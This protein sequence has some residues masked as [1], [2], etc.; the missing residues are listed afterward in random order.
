[1][2]RLEHEA[3]S[4]RVVYFYKNEENLGEKL[5][6]K[7]TTKHFVEEGKDKSVIFNVIKRF[8]TRGTIDYKKITGRPAFRDIICVEKILKKDSEISIRNGAQKVQIYLNECLIK[9]LL[10]FILKN[11]TKLKIFCCGLICRLL[12]IKKMC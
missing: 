2:T 10:P 5:A 6:L 1:M 7:L 12:T 3:F 9:I 11:T 4:K 8:R